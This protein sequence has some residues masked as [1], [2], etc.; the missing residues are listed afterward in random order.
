MERP[1]PEDRV[2]L[3]EPPEDSRPTAEDPEP[4]EQIEVAEQIMRRYQEALH[5]LA[6]GPEVVTA[7]LAIASG[8][9]SEMQ[10]AAWLDRNSR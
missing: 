4:A 2:Y 9:W 8:E 7:M 3:R 10:F 1:K 6:K 5:Q